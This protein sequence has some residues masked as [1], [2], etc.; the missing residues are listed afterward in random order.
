MTHF[1]P[2]ARLY[3]WS[4][5]YLTICCPFGKTTSITNYDI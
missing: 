2:A 4:W 3:A 1:V 5:Q